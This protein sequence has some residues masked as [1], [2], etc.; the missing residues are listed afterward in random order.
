MSFYPPAAPVVTPVTQTVTMSPVQSITGQRYDTIPGNLE[1]ENDY[2]L[3]TED[4]GFIL[5]EN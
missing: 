4:G 5:L 1:Q 2:D 3:L